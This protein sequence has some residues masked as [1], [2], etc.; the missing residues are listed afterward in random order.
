MKLPM[1]RTRL[2]ASIKFASAAALAGLLLT[3]AAA[4]AQ[5]RSGGFLDNLFNRGQ[6]SQ[7]P[8]EQAQQQPSC[9]RG[10]NGVDSRIDR[11]EAALRQLTGR[12]EELQ[13]QNQ[14]LQMQLN[15]LQGGGAPP[16]T[17]NA[18]GRASNPPPMSNSPDNQ[19]G[20]AFNPA[21]H[22]NAPGAPR[23]LGGGG[24]SEMP[25]PSRTGM[26]TGMQNGMQTGMNAPPIGTSEGR[27][28][29][30]PLDLNSLAGPGQAPQF[31][32]GGLPP[33]PPRNP[34][35][36]GTQL[37][38]LPPSASPKDEYELAYGYVL[39]K[40]YGLAAQAFRDFI[41]KYPN[42]KLVPDAQ[43]WLGESLY[44]QQ[45]YTDA[46]KE[47]LNVATKYG[48]SAKAPEALL[49]LGQSLAALHKKEAACA[50]LAEVGR[51]FPHAS[52]SVR[53]GVAQEQKRAHC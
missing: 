29:G 3:S 17:A 49:R 37:A 23:P 31:Q 46:A 34:S 47:F 35:A 45:S 14:Q 44:Q 4:M 48:H 12:V 26:Q 40:D 38:T 52:T 33:P 43:Y 41:R 30:A 8:Q 10:G 24:R 7:Q 19:R 53:R 5:D 32:N 16:P 50:T 21:R 15:R 11:I 39:H 25:P 27:G 18:P 42:E 2:L 1:T 51:K 6:S 28:A 22:P 13:H 20:D 36:T 9:G